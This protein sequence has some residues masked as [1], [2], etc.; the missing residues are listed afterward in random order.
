M[1]ST[2]RNPAQNCPSFDAANKGP[3]KRAQRQTKTLIRTLKPN[4]V[5]RAHGLYLGLFAD[6]GM[7]LGDV[8]A[9]ERDNRC[10]A[11]VRGVRVDHDGGACSFCLGQRVGEIGNLEAGYF[12]PVRIRKM[13]VGDQHG[14]LAEV[15]FDPDAAVGIVW[16]ADLDAR[17]AA[18][19]GN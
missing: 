18:V 15:G 16:P 19:I 2:W 3:T 14:C 7:D 12:A 9:G 4:G 8:T 11:S 10:L 5:E 6:R 1:Y 17:S 13:P